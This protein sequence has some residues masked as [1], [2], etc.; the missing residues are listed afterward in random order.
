LPA[1]LCL[2]SPAAVAHHSTVGIYNEDVVVEISGRVKEWRFV[3]PHPSL[4]VEVEGPDGAIQEWD[5]SY[6]GPAV[7][8]LKRVGYTADTFKPGD[9]IVAQGYAARVQTAF[10]LLI[11]GHP[12]RLDGSVIIDAPPLYAQPPDSR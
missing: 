12:T 5:I 10:G 11:I 8:Q 7:T 2:S 9:M 1:L 3:N 6:G 4:I